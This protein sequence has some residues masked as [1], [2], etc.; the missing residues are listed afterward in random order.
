MKRIRQKN[1]RCRAAA[2]ALLAFTLF[3]AG[4]GKETSGSEETL[5][6]STA[7]S[8]EQTASTEQ[9]VTAE[10]TVSAD[11]EES[12]TP[13]SSE[14]TPGRFQYNEKLFALGLPVVTE[15]QAKADGKTVLTLQASL[16]NPWLKD[17]IA[18]FNRQS[19]DYFV[20]LEETYEDGVKD[21]VA[22]EIVA[23]RGP[24]ILTGSV[25]EISES[26]LEKEVLVDLAP[27]LDAMG[28]T[29]EE[30]FPGVRA[31]PMGDKVYGIRTYLTPHGYWIRESVLGGRELPDIATLVEK[32]YTY[33]DQETVWRTN[34]RSV[35]ILEYLLCGSEDLWGM[36]DW[37]KGTCDFS[38]ELFAK[39]L[40]I[41]KRYADPEGRTEETEDKWMVSFYSPVSNTPRRQLEK[42][43]KVIINYSFDNGYYPAYESI[44][45]V[46]MMNANS[47]HQ[48][49]VWAFFEYVLGEEGQCYAA[50][51]SYLAVN[52]EMSKSCMEYY[53]RGLEEGW[54]KTTAEF[55]P[56]TIE[57]LYAF[58]EQARPLPLR[59]KEVLDIIYEESETFWAGDK[60][61]EEV[62]D[63]IQKRVQIYI[64]ENM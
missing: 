29:D 54:F 6:E 18:G 61:L 56:E 49:G 20:R 50:G 7:E 64:S 2:M 9:T 5:A 27:G 3:L 40:E 4:C 22:A 12:D 28:I 46:L 58:T 23:G 17:S 25:L 43:G 52:R 45:E 19:A 26:V 13:D 60:P 15:E 48:E 10:P 55:T 59:T 1:L 14:D 16:V 57:E 63:V 36:I 39:M 35:R 11:T 21:R 37:E 38:G 44:S 34:A 62:C 33:P 32:L 51:N 31:L 41:A 42:E 53:L 24:D 8:M 30:Y 47:E